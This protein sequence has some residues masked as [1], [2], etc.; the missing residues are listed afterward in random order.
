MCLCYVVKCFNEPIKVVIIDPT[1]H[2]SPSCLVFGKLLKV[3]FIIDFTGGIF[4]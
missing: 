1:F 4:F 3:E 2:L